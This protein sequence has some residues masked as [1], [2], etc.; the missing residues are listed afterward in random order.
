MQLVASHLPVIDALTYRSC[1][2]FIALLFFSKG[3]FDSANVSDVF[4]NE[5]K[6]ATRPRSIAR[7]N[8]TTTY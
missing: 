1:N 2:E 7:E 3:D 4:I 8:L 6:T 5:Q